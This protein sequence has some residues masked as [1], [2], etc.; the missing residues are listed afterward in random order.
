MIESPIEDWVCEKA[1]ADGWI[2]RKLKWAGRRNGMDR[3][4]LKAGRIVLIEFKRPDGKPRA[5]QQ[6]EID[7]FREAGAE[8]HVI[9]NPLAG[10]RVLGIEYA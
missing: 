9:D 4:F 8:V 6:R 2:V 10:L 5:T 1:E 3:F 7:L